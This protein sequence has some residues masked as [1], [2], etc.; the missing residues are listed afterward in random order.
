MTTHADLM[1][2]YAVFDRVMSS[3]STLIVG[4]DDRLARSFKG[5]AAARGIP[6]ISSDLVDGGTELRVTVI[7]QHGC[8]VISVIAPSDRS[9]A[10]VSR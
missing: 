4:R 9:R 3:S 8:A 1:A 2:D 10:P 6:M 5:W 7:Q